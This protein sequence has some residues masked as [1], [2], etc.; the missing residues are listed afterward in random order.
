MFALI[1]LNVPHE[2]GLHHIV[3]A[4]V[5]SVCDD[6]EL[7]NRV[8]VQPEAL[9]YF[10]G[11]HIV[12]TFLYR[13]CITQNI[14]IDIQRQMQINYKR[15]RFAPPRAGFCR[16]ASPIFRPVF[17]AEIFTIPANYAM[18]DTQRYRGTNTA[19]G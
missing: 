11:M 3:Q 17:S 14:I 12:R 1:L 15:M 6:A 5:F 18:M 9:L 2:D 10:I 7:F 8:M 16:F 19:S 13:V 4:S